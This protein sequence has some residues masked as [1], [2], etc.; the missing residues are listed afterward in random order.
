MRLKNGGK[1]MDSDQQRKSG[2]GWFA[3]S[4]SMFMNLVGMASIADAW[5]S[6]SAFSM[7]FVD[8]YRHLTALLFSPV[9]TFFEVDIPVIV[10]DVVI[11]W[12]AFGLLGMRIL[13]M[14]ERNDDVPFFWVVKFLITP[15]FLVFVVYKVLMDGE[16]R[17][18]HWIAAIVWVV[19]SVGPLVL[20]VFIDWQF[21]QNS[22][23]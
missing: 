5:Y 23:V 22:H 7:D 8:V 9:A 18:K 15:F 19:A 21:L 6:W 11:V 14:Y 10:R 17:N 1:L 4:F 3:L 2:W 20:A 16:F 12:G 13:D